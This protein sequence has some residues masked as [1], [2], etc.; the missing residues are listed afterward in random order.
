MTEEKE[1]KKQQ[2][3]SYAKDGVKSQKMMAFRCDLD[4]MRILEQVKNKGRLLNDLVRAWAAK[5]PYEGDE[6]SPK[7][8]DIEEY[9]N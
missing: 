1:V 9:M 8:W 3:K 2:R 5:Q 6:I 7:E 4:V